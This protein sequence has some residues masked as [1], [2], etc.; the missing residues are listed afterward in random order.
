MCAMLSMFMILQQAVHPWRSFS[1]SV[2]EGAISCA[3]G[4]RP[5]FAVMVGDMH[6]NKEVVKILGTTMFAGVCRC[7]TRRDPQ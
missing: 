7:T 6:A 5:M 2:F 3:M 4:I 1:N